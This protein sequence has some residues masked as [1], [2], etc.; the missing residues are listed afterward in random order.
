[1][2][3]WPWQIDR[4]ISQN[5]SR[6][7]RIGLISAVNFW[8][9]ARKSWRG[10]RT[11]VTVTSTGSSCAFRNS[12]SIRRNSPATMARANGAAALAGGRGSM[13]TPTT[14][15]RADGRSLDR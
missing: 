15:G 11:L 14:I 10:C 3:S 7:R 12:F 13:T 1:L 8:K 9:P 4:N 2:V 6:R 5:T